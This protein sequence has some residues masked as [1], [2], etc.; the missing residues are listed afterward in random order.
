[1]PANQGM[2]SG[3]KHRAEVFSTKGS[4]AIGSFIERFIRTFRPE[5]FDAYVLENPE[6]VRESVEIWLQVFNHE[7]AHDDLCRCHRARSSRGH[8]CRDSLQSVCVLDGRAYSGL[9][10]LS[11]M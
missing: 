3:E 7:L 1:M 4:P 9:A 10:Q 2:V 6:Q 8:T 5:L 11:R